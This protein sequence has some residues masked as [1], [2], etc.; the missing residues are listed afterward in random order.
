MCGG[1]SVPHDRQDDESWL[2]RLW[3]RLFGEQLDQALE[4]LDWPREDRRLAEQVTPP[5]T[6]FAAQEGYRAAAALGVEAPPGIWDTVVQAIREYAFADVGMI[7]DTSRELL[8]DALAQFV[9]EG[10]T[11][12]RLNEEV[13]KIFGPERA[14]RIA[15]TEL[16]R[17]YTEGK[18][19]T[20]DELRAAGLEVV[21]IWHTVNDELVCE[22]CGPRN[23]KRLGDGW[24]RSDGPPAHP[25]CRCSI[26]IRGL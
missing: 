25:N 9:E 18:R 1:Y 21:E 19:A 5:L 3:A 12:G 17:A 14:N 13:A 6:G 4:G 7:N 22:I 15:V 26:D 11:M 2:S 20:V 23:G 24:D 8:Q 16:T 10:W